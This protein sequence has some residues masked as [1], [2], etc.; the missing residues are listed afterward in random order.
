MRAYPPK[1][2][3]VGSIFAR[4]SA[5]N[6]ERRKLEAKQQEAVKE[7]AL[8]RGEAERFRAEA[9]LGEIDIISGWSE[10]L[11]CLQDQRANRDARKRMRYFP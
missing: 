9:S 3:D 11:P 4:L 2:P 7:A 5:L 1:P 10:G 6:D 8:K